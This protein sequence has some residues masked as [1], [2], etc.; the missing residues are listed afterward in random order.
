MYKIPLKLYTVP[1]QSQLNLT[2]IMKFTFKCDNPV[3]SQKH[4]NRCNRSG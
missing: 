3:S 1:N 4:H 2:A